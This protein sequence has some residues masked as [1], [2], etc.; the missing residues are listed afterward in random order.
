MLEQ[1]TSAG[2]PQQLVLPSEV[3]KA[4]REWW[5][6]AHMALCGNCCRVSVLHREFAETYQLAAWKKQDEA[7]DHQ[8]AN[9][10]TSRRK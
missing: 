10:S 4:S 9:L 7:K 8:L 6:A 2:I 5:N 1:S 3:F